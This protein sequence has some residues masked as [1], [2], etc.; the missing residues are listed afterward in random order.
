MKP[1]HEIMGKEFW[2]RYEA[3]LKQATTNEQIEAVFNK[4]KTEWYNLCNHKK[5]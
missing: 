3:E 1:I 4:I 5:V 2:K